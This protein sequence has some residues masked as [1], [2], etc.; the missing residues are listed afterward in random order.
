[1]KKFTLYIPLIGGIICIVLAILL[2]VYTYTMLE[3]SVE[4]M[5]KMIAT[6]LLLIA[7]SIYLIIQFI[8]DIEGISYWKG[9]DR[10][11]DDAKKDIPF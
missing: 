9:H 1:M 8:S 5:C 6:W 11:Y 2:V 4:T 3:P 7:L 10:G